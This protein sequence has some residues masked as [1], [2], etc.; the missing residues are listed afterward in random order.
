MSYGC[1]W[2][3]M[4]SFPSR[5]VERPGGALGHGHQ[6]TILSSSASSDLAGIV[7]TDSIIL[8][9]SST[10]TGAGEGGAHRKGDISDGL[11]A[12]ACRAAQLTTMGRS[13]GLT[14]RD[15][16]SQLSDALFGNLSQIFI[17]G[18]DEIEV[19]V[20][21]PDDERHAQATLDS[22]QLQ[23]PGGGF[24]PLMTAVKLEPHQGF[25]ILRHYNGRLSATVFADVDRTRNNANRIREQLRK[26]VIPELEGKWGVEASYT[27]RAEDQKETLADMKQGAFFALAM[28][29]IRCPPWRERSEGAKGDPKGASERGVQSYGR[30]VCSRNELAMLWRNAG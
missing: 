23:L 4:S 24:M 8:V 29:Y 17:K 6:L 20:M 9:P 7:V 30:P 1:S 26:K 16:A 2:C 3:V 18:R 15:V 11:P 13:R 12:P 27:G 21:L 25:E 14:E 28:I 19:R 10:S 22:L 5:I